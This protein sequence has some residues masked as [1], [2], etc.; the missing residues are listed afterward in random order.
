MTLA[1][2]R[3]GDNLT[4]EPVAGQGVLRRLW[5][6][7]VLPGSTVKVLASH[8]FRGPVVIA[9]DGIQVAIGRGLAAK[10]PVSRA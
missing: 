2:A 4:V 5:D 7:G 9:A 10:V 6:L 3:P 1:E 8:P